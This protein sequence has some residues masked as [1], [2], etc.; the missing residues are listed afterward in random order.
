MWLGSWVQCHSNQHVRNAG[1]CINEL[2]G[3][4]CQLVPHHF[5][6]SQQFAEDSLVRAPSAQE[7]PF[8]ATQKSVPSL[9]GKQLGYAQCDLPSLGLF[10]LGVTAHI[11]ELEPQD[12]QHDCN[13]S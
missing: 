3:R 2:C 12:Q 10:A 11:A 7:L 4:T 6:D 13:G 8:L 5:V 9:V 1:C